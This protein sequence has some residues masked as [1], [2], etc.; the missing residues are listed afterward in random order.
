[1]ETLLGSTPGSG[2]NALTPSATILACRRENAQTDDDN[3]ISSI[4]S[5]ENS[6][7]NVQPSPL[8][9]PSTARS[10]RNDS[11]TV[12]ERSLNRST[13]V[14][15]EL[16]RAYTN[17]QPPPPQESAVTRAV[18]R[19]TNLDVVVALE[20]L[21]RISLLRQMAKD[22]NAD[23]VLALRE[24]DLGPFV[25]TLLAELTTPR[26]PPPPP[27]QGPYYTGYPRY[28]PPAS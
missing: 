11:T 9:R 10:H 12:I 1:M 18:A 28:P 22:G 15:A 24:E 8:P 25:Q 20:P 13:E 3:T 21:R 23:V 5:G 7:P 2:L 17:R 4:G 6:G 14:L 27:P 26:Q 16:T 19:I